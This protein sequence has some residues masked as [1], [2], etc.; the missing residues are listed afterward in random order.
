M[1]CSEPKQ[2]PRL[3][4]VLRPALAV[5]VHGAEPGLRPGFAYRDRVRVRARVRVSVKGE[6]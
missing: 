5:V 2:P 3:G 1:R 4:K 6:R